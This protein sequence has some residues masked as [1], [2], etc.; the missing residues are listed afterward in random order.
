MWDRNG[1]IR[2]IRVSLTFH[3]VFRSPYTV[4]RCIIGQ[5]W[6]AEHCYAL[7]CIVCMCLCYL[8]RVLL[9]L[10]KTPSMKLQVPLPPPTRHGSEVHRMST[11]GYKFPGA[12]MP[13]AR[14]TSM[15]M[16]LLSAMSPKN[17]G[18]DNSTK[19]NALAP[20]HEAINK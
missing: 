3:N 18:Q 19:P 1:A 2:V 13:W 20:N 10:S 9:P 7:L 4:V 11:R 6:R 12:D 8:L 16:F 5:T 14:T 15:V 17:L